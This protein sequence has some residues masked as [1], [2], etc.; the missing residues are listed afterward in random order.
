MGSYPCIAQA[1][2]EVTYEVFLLC[3]AKLDT[4]IMHMTVLLS[5][6]LIAYVL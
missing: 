1:C 3:H 5:L 2:L 4:L 6:L